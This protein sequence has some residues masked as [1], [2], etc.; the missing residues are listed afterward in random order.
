MRLVHRD[1]V[2]SKEEYAVKDEGGDRRDPEEDEVAAGKRA[3]E[4]ATHE[5]KPPATP[6]AWGWGWA[7]WVLLEVKWRM[8]L[9]WD[10][11]GGVGWRW[12]GRCGVGWGETVVGHDAVWWCR[13]ACQRGVTR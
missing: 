3:D 1:S 7:G 8:G 10:T 12:V 9:S 13:V 2:D 4:R 11:W 5:A 6:V